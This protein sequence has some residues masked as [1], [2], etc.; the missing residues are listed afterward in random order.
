[1]KGNI[2]HHANIC[3]DDNFDKRSSNTQ[4]GCKTN[5]TFVPGVGDYDISKPE[6]DMRQKSPNATIGNDR[7]FAKDGTL[8]EYKKTTPHFY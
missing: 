6:I 5:R 4:F 2:L 3:S 7:R 1:M 8:H